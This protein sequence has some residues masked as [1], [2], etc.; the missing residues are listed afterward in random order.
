MTTGVSN[1]FLQLQSIRLLNQG[2]A[3]LADL[4][5]QLAT[6]LKTS[7]LSELGT[8]D[9]RRLLD[10]R[11]DQSTRTAYTQVI[12]ILQPRVQTQNSILDN[13]QDMISTIQSAINQAPSSTTSVQTGLAQQVTD[14]LHQTGAY[15][16]E[17]IDDRYLFSGSRYNTSPVTDL[18]TLPSPP[19]EAYPFTPVTATS[20]PALPSYDSDYNATPSA[21]DDTTV[22]S[23][24]ATN[25]TS[26]FTLGTGSWAS[27]GYKVGDTV[28]FSNLSVG[29]NN[30]TYTITSMNGGD[31]VVTP[32]PTDMA[33]D[34]TVNLQRTAG[35]GAPDVQ[36]YQADS[37][38]IDDGLTANYGITSTNPAFQNMIMGLRWAYAATQDPANYSTYMQ[39]ATDLLSQAQNGV[40]GLEAANSAN[41]ALLTKTLATHQTFNDQSTTSE[42]AIQGADTNEVATRITLLQSQIEASYS[43]TARIGQ[44]SL[45]NY[46]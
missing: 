27:L 10:L 32:A 25:A 6:Q 44:L 41:A 11:A 1:V 8:T 37:T 21:V 28:T 22:G 31:A 30:T 14:V 15:L 42:Q 3:Q 38:A 16:N 23:V 17:R 29:G 4:Q 43:V 13:M 40:R 7:D 33:A 39:R 45:V 9:S 2:Q 35:P 20:D 12:N 19:T 34:T 46:L 26:T 18:T 24:T 5:Q 36:A